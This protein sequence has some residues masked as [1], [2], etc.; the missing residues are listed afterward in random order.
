MT[1]EAVAANRVHRNIFTGIYK[2]QHAGCRGGKHRNRP[3]KDI[4]RLLVNQ[5][6]HSDQRNKLKNHRTDGNI[7][8]LLQPL[9]H[10]LHTNGVKNH[11]AA[12]N[13]IQH[14]IRLKSWNRYQRDCQGK[15]RKSSHNQIDHRK[16]MHHSGQFQTIISYLRCRT[17]AV[18]GNSQLGKHGKIIDKRGREIYLP[19]ARRKQNPRNIRKSNQRENNTRHG[20]QSIHDK[21]FFNRNLPAHLLSLSLLSMIE[22]LQTALFRNLCTEMFPNFPQNPICYNIKALIKMAQVFLSCSQTPADR[23]H[24]YMILSFA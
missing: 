8:I 9:I 18:G 1:P 23:P 10:P 7:S 15:I 17:N 12:D 11:R 19:C 4:I 14:P 2:I 3:I 21:I 6:K 24:E 5:Q 20:Q 13:K 16:L 22:S